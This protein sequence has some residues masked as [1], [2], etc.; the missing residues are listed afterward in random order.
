MKWLILEFSRIKFRE[1]RRSAQLH[2]FTTA[3]NRKLADS[4]LY[5]TPAGQP[6]PQLQSDCVENTA[7]SLVR[8]DFERHL[9]KVLWVKSYVICLLKQLQLSNTK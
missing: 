1:S 2:F 9:S 8:T 3:L 7:L 6:L 4:V 5:G